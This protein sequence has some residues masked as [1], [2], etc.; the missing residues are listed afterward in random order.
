MA[1]RIAFMAKVVLRFFDLTRWNR[2]FK[3]VR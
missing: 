3:L 2:M 1:D